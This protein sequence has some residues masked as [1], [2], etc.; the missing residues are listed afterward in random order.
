MENKDF[1]TY[2]YMSKNVKSKEQAQVC[3]IYEAFGWEISSVQ[4]TG[5]D[6]ST[7]SFKRDRKIRHKAELAKLERQASET[8]EEIRKLEQSKTTGASIFGY[9]FGTFAALVFG[10][11]MSLCML[12]TANI[13]ALVGGIVLGIVGAVLCG[14]NYL[15]Y[16]KIAE[17]RTKNVLPVIDERQEKLANLLEQGNDLINTD[18]I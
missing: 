9:T 10:G 11:G 18:L 7:I 15:A 12:Q 13:P 1:V 3:D 17:K 4:S 6:T 8:Y 16:K 2:E 5:L 14:V